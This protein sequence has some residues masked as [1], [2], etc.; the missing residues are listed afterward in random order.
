MVGLDTLSSLMAA[1]TASEIPKTSHSRVGDDTNATQVPQM[2]PVPA[3]NAQAKDAKHAAANFSMVPPL[4]LLCLTTATN[5]K[6]NETVFQA[7]NTTK[8]SHYM[9][10]GK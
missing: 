6:K 8:I 3:E 10:A 1:G 7:T 4:Q 2:L 9:D 5:V